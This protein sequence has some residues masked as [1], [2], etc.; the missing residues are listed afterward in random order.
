M[1]RGGKPLRRAP[2]R[3]RKKPPRADGRI[4]VEIL[5]GETMFK[6]ELEFIIKADRGTAVKEVLEIVDFIK[7]AH[8]NAKIVVEVEV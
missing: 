6:K 7:K 1:S 4:T 8:P 5:E 2:A 3:G